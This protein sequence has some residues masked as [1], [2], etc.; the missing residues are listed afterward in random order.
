MRKGEEFKSVA[1]IPG[2]GLAIVVAQI[3]FELKYTLLGLSNLQWTFV[4]LTAVSIPL[5]LRNWRR[6]AADR[7]VQTTALFVAVQWLAAAYAPDLHTNAFKASIRF[8]AGFVLL[9]IVRVLN[10]NKVLSRVWVITASIA[11]VYALVAY[12]GFGAPWL[13]RNEEFYVGQVQRLSGSFEYP[14]TAAVYFAMSL[15]IV[16]WSSF[17]SVWRWLSAFLLWCT[18][19]LTFSKGA[20]LALAIVVLGAPLVFWR[21]TLRWRTAATLLAVA[22]SSYG[23]LTIVIP[24]RIER[25]SAQNPTTAEYRTPW[26]QLMQR[27][28]T[29]DQ[30]PVIVRN[31]GVTKWRSDGR[32]RVAISYRWWR[33]DAKTFLKIRPLVT[34]LPHDVDR[35]ET[36]SIPVSFQTPAQP[37]KYVLVI[38]LF[39]RD[40]DWFNQTGEDPIL[41]Q[42]DIQ[43][44]TSRS[45]GRTDLSALY[46]TGKTANSPDASVPRSSLWRAAL[47]M[48]QAHPFGVGPDNY[49][50]QYGKFL[51]ASNWDT[52]IYSNNLYLEVLTGSGILGLGAFALV[53]L[54]MNW[55]SEAP[56]LAAAVFLVH[57]T[58]R[59]CTVQSLARHSL[60]A[61]PALAGETDERGAEV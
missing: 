7:L 11:A 55:R 20:L 50:L 13:F 61:I 5:L 39:S 54:S 14:N 26:N 53:V 51:G 40:F 45:V 34:T 38:D 9:M 44:S 25:M 47:K 32:L 35:G 59:S 4:G 12:T 42:A 16:M 58:V 33:A 23:V 43:P 15:P 57:R 28:E 6:L 17:S 52:R 2:F 56:C 37:G 1:R 60:S 48:F 3:P 27:P 18:V 8:T 49:R 21:N 30:V 24:Y 19:V 10:D 41:I 36:I 22:V 29:Y 46:R 31:T